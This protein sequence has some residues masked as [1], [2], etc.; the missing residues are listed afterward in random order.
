MMILPSELL[1]ERFEVVSR[2]IAPLEFKDLQ[3][4]GLESDQ[5]TSKDL[6]L[7]YPGKSACEELEEKLHFEQERREQLVEQVRQETQNHTALMQE[8]EAKVTSIHEKVEEVCGQFFK[9]RGK[10][11]ADIEAEVVRLALAVASRI[12]YREVLLDPL[13]LRGSVRVALE[14][15]KENSGV[16]LRVPNTQEE[17]WRSLLEGTA[18][19]EITVVADS[20]MQAGECLLETSVGRVDLGIQ[21]QLEEIERG[22]FDLLQQRPA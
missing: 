7:E 8:M 4:A 1:S 19:R 12:L 15:L 9:E 3:A 6:E 17:D 21:A 11:F 10:Y 20:T 22:F 5:T 16:S 18:G 2:E 13:L 14:K